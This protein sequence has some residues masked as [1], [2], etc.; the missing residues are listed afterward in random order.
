[1]FVFCLIPVLEIIERTPY[2][3]KAF[4]VL[5]VAL[6]LVIDVQA[7]LSS[8]KYRYDAPS[9][10]KQLIDYCATKYGVEQCTLKAQH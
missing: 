6:A 2:I 10:E 4:I 8:E 3:R 1:M 5:A 7:S 9:L